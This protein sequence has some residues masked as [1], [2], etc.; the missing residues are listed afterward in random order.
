MTTRSF[1]CFPHPATPHLYT[2][3]LHDALPISRISGPIVRT[4]VDH[5]RN[6]QLAPR[7]RPRDV[8]TSLKVEDRKT[9]SLNCSHVGKS[10]AVCSLKNQRLPRFCIERMVRDAAG[11][12]ISVFLG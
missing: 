1:F 3:S 4:N 2:L 7:L 8:R 10:Y 11:T 9:T 6:P 5:I 12:C